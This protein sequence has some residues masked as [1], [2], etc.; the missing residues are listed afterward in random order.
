[1]TEK[2]IDLHVHSNAS[3]GSMRPAEI[4]ELA[5]NLNLS[6]VALTDHDTVS[7]IP[8]FMERGRNLPIHTIPGVE[9]SAALQS[10]EVHIVGLFIDYNS[11]S[12]NELLFRIREDRDRRNISMISKL[13]SLGYEISIDEVLAIAGGET[14]GRPHFAQILMQKGYFSDVRDVFD[15]CLKRGAPAYCVRKIP[16][17]EEVISEI[18]KAGGLAIWAHPV[19]KRSNPRPYVRQTLRKLKDMGIDGVECYYSSYSPEQQKMMLDITSDFN[20]LKSGGSDFHGQN[21]PSVSLGT[22]TGSLQ[23]PESIYFELEAKVKERNKAE[24]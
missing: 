4:L 19:Y 2:Y 14:V 8:E 7:G 24:V 3:D 15:N 13:R 1:M 18:H 21:Q 5:N 20:L 17:P 11:K 16:K 10:N 6:A 12:L 23:V 22:G 9:I